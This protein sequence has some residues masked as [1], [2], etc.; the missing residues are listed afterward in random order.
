MSNTAFNDPDGI[1]EITTPYRGD[2]RCRK[3]VVTDTGSVLGNIEAYDVRNFG[4]IHGRI[5][6]DDVFIN[7]E[8]ASFRG[9][10][11]APHLGVHPNSVFEA[12]SSNSE[13]YGSAPVLPVMPSAIES[14]IQEGLRRELSKRNLG[15]ADDQGFTLSPNT[16]FART[17][18]VPASAPD[19]GDI[20]TASVAGETADVSHT[21]A[22][23]TPVTAIKQAEG[24][25]VDLAWAPPGRSGGLRMSEEALASLRTNG[26]KPPKA[27]QPRPLPLLFAQGK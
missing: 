1:V 5:N 24:P 2:I 21:V 3:L 9:S 20:P 17:G 6:A 19:A 27:Q 11:Y 22:E 13:R 25:P 8:G 16:T 14:A 26:V 10:V 15:V 18:P 7:A 23:D 12:S 4:R